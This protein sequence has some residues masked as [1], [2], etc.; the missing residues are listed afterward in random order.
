MTDIYLWVDHE[1]IQSKTLKRLGGLGFVWVGHTYMLLEMQACVKTKQ[2]QWFKLN[3]F[4]II[5]S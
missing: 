4:R 5:S 1:N 3:L 2:S